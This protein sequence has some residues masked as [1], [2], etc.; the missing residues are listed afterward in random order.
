MSI[1]LPA[2]VLVYAWRASPDGK[3]LWVWG[4]DNKL[5]CIDSQNQTTPPVPIAFPRSALVSKWNLS[6]EWTLLWVWGTDHSLYCI[7]SKNK[8][9]PLVPIELPSGV[10]LRDS[11]PSPDGRFLW[12]EGTDSNLYCIDSQNQKIACVPITFPSGVG[13]HIAW[14]P[15]SDGTLL[16][17]LG[18]DKNL[19]CI[20]SKNPAIARKP[21]ILPSG[22]GVKMLKYSAD[23][24]WLV[25]SGNDNKLYSIDSARPSSP[26]VPIALP[27]EEVEQWWVIADG[28]QVLVQGTDGG[29]YMVKV[30]H[31]SPA[32]MTKKIKAQMHT[33][34][35]PDC[36]IPE[37]TGG[38]V[39]S[40][41][42]RLSQSNDTEYPGEDYEYA[43]KSS[44]TMNGVIHEILR[45]MRLKRNILLV[46]PVGT[47]KTWVVKAV[48]RLL[49][50]RIEMISVH[51]GTTERDLTCWP[52]T[53]REGGE[54]STDYELSALAV[55]MLEG[56]TCLVDE[57]NRGDT[58]CLLYTSP[59]PRD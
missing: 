39:V 18:N 49:K 32:A 15:S 41:G 46:G 24:Q 10:R 36:G 59:S 42:M 35:V 54:L 44:P 3:S 53:K 40:G 30:P 28:T 7:S 48:M 14:T 11:I 29:L 16:W 13:S 57:V 21:I 38:S 23:G 31:G 27:A 12:V 45:G 52:K 19:Y 26:P 4:T 1:D 56:R 51:E 47:G 43:P 37:I 22:N 9:T 17:V 25:V 34:Y 55:A 33:S 2:D 6:L 8:K 50:K 58:G 20:D 5:Y